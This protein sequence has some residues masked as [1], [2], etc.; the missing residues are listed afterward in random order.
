MSWMEKIK[1]KTD[2]WIDLD[3]ETGWKNLNAGTGYPCGHAPPP[4]HDLTLGMIGF[5]EILEI[6]LYIHIYIEKEKKKL[7]KCIEKKK[8]DKSNENKKKK[9]NS[10]SLSTLCGALTRSPGSVLRSVSR[11]K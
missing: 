10:N 1:I 4:V 7:K 6:L 3:D 5:D 8:R 9:E 11:G 2:R